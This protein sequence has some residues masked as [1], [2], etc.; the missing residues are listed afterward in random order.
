MKSK[1]KV[2]V[3]VTISDGAYFPETVVEAVEE[4]PADPHKDEQSLIVQSLRDH[5]GTLSG[6]EA[7]DIDTILIGQEP[8][9]GDFYA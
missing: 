4:N 5:F 7:G 3:E 1:I 8:E 2:T 9:E 6:V